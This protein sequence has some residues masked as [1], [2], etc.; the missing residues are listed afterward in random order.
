MLRSFLLATSI[1]VLNAS[2]SL[3]CSMAKSIETAQN[4]VPAQ[5]AQAPTQTLIPTEPT[6]SEVAE[7]PKT[8]TTKTN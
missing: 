4:P 5:T 8:E 3:A 1:V 2:T 6:K 7:A